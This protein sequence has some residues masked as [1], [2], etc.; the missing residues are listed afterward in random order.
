MKQKPTDYRN[1]I[2]ALEYVNSADLTPL[3]GGKILFDFCRFLLPGILSELVIKPVKRHLVSRKGVDL[4]GRYVYSD[5]QGVKLFQSYPSTFSFSGTNANAL[6]RIGNSVPPLFMEAIARH[7][8]R[9]ILDRA[10]A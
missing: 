7:I 9:E 2:K 4:E 5:A 10:E 8:R 1:R 3:E 6:D